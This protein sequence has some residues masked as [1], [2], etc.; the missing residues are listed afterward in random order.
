MVQPAP[1]GRNPFDETGV[2]RGADGVARYVDRPASLVHLLRASVERDAAASAVVEV[3]G[4]SLSYGELWDRAARVAGGLRRRWASSAAIA[5]RSACRTGSTGCSPSSARSWPAR[6]SSRS[7]PASPRTRSAYVVERLRERLH[8]CAT[9]AALPDGDAVGRRGS[10]ARRSRGDLLHERHDR[11]SEGCDDL[12]RELHRQQRE[13][14]PCILNR[15]L[16]RDRRSRTL[17]SVPLCSTSPAA[18]AS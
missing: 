9:A 4:G 18:T 17:V 12:A 1:R 7:T 8:V 11:L 16:R 15:A 10:R 13:H 2:E 5:S 3:G 14:L 6:S